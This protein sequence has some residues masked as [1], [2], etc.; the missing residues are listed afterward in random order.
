ML[1]IICN[2]SL[3]DLECKFDYE[4]KWVVL[5]YSLLKQVKDY[6]KLNSGYSAQSWTA[7]STLLFFHY[8][9]PHT[10]GA[11]IAGSTVITD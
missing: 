7:L 5:K 10:A 4:W 9:P 3:Q 11:S 8:M 6:S 2:E 1:D